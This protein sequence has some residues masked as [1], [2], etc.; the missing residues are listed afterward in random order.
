MSH[1]EDSWPAP[2]DADLRA[3]W[4]A[5]YRENNRELVPARVLLENRHLLPPKGRALDL[6]CGLGANALL[7]A[8]FG[9][10]VSAWDL[11]AVAIDRLTDAASARGLRIDAEVRDLQAHP[12]EPGAF[13]VIVVS[14]FLDRALAPK[15]AEALRSGALL[16]YQ[17]FTREAV[18][19][20]GPSNPEYRLSVNELLRLFP[21][22]VV[23]VYREEGRLGDR[24]L[25]A[26]DIAM[27]VAERPRS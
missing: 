24:T 17:T 23:R 10:Q 11:S 18:S 16:F 22:L 25:G 13:D 4:D 12:P 26:R 3:K 8:E 6:A 21:G 5:R 9:L 2:P 15:I 14:H 19:D 27:L 7:L 1:S 20:G